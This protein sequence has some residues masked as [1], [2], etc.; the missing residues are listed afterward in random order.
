M[1]TFQS[2]FEGRD[3]DLLQQ[4]GFFDQGQ[5]QAERDRRGAIRQA[6][7]DELGPDPG[8][9]EAATYDAVLRRRLEHLAASPARMVLVSLED[10]WRE[11]EPQNVP[12]TTTEKPNWRRKARLSFE[13]FSKQ[14][15]VVEALRRV[16]ELRRGR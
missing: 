16:D 10:L 6:M 14:P 15:E 3:I 4:L 5:A 7:V 8:R 1:P 2:F 12:G 9:S 11:P 13:E